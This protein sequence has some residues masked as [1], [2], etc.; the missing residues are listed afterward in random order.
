MSVDLGCIAKGYIADR[1]KEYLVS[2]GVESATI[3]LGGNVLCIGTHPDGTPF[4]IGI[5]KPFA[6]RNETMAIADIEDLSVVTS[7]IYE[8]YFQED[9]VLY[10]HI[11]NPDTGY[12]Y[13]NDLTSVTIISQDSADG[14]G[15]S[16]ACFALGLQEGLKLV[17][18]AVPK[19]YGIFVTKDGG[20]HYSRDLQKDISLSQ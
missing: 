1:M 9:G 2:H 18:A 20:V 19:A 7:G 8:R 11:L 17:E 5:Q 12:P 13:D 15:L 14:D 3:T 10:H 4:H 16:T 6:D